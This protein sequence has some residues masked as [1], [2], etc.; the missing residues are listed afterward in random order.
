MILQNCGGFK[1]VFCGG[2]RSDISWGCI[3]GRTLSNALRSRGRDCQHSPMS[4][5][6]AVPLFGF[7]F[8][9]ENIVTFDID[10]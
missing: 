3:P 8:Q 1:R 6:Y 10:V 5:D 2:S 9:Q 4:G 7:A